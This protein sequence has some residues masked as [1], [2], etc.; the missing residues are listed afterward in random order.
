MKKFKVGDKVRI[1]EKQDELGEVGLIGTI[2]GVLDQR[3]YDYYHIE[4]PEGFHG[5]S[6]GG[7]IENDRGYSVSSKRI[8]LVEKGTRLKPK[9][10]DF[11]RYMVYGTGC[12]NKSELFISEKEMSEQAKAFVEDDSW[13]G[14]IIGYKLIPLFEAKTKVMIKKFAKA[15]AKKE[16]KKKAK[17]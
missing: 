4:F 9:P 6:C 8:E 16:T 1:I 14:K 7:L 10:E 2:R 13:S 15:K 17:K 5:H 11:T 3:G 12:D